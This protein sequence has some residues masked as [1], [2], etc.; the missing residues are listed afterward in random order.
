LEVEI[1]HYLGKVRQKTLTEQ[2]SVEFQGLM[3]ATNDVESL[4]DVIETD[5]VSLGRKWADL[6]SAP[7][8]KTRNMLIELHTTVCHS[9]ELTVQAIRDNDQRAAESVMMMK[10]KVREQS[11][12]LLTRKAERLTVEDSDYLELVRMEMSFVDQMRRIYTL[13]KRIAKT[14]LPPVLAQRD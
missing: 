6:Q 8:E 7:G 4:A 14:V 3:T 1:L 12:M 2:E 9:V 11:E 13:T 5:L 10:D